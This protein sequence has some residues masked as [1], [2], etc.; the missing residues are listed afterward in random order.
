LE[1]VTQQGAPHMQ[2]EAHKRE[3]EEAHPHMPVEEP[4]VQGMEPV[5]DN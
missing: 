3:R 2:E 4:G 5:G 1:P